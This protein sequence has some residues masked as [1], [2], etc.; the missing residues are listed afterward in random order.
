MPRTLNSGSLRT[1]LGATNRRLVRNLVL[2]ALVTLGLCFLALVYFDKRL[3]DTLSHKLIDQ[4][5]LAISSKLDAY[6]SPFEQGL[7][8]AQEQ[9]ERV[10]FFSGHLAEDFYHVMKPFLRN[11]PHLSAAIAGNIQGSSLFILNDGNGV[12]T[13]EIDMRAK[14]GI[15]QWRRWQDGKVEESWSRRADFDPRTRPWFRN[16]ADKDPGA[17]AYT[18]PYVFYTTQ[19]PGISISRKWRHGETGEEYVLAWDIILQDL[20]ILT[21]SLR[22]TEHGLAMVVTDDATLVGLPAAKRYAQPEARAAAVLES[23]DALDL[24][25]V[26]DAF[27][28]WEQRGRPADIFR[29]RTQGQPWWA[30]FVAYEYLPGRR[31]WTAA[32]VP[33]SDFLAGLSRTRNL[34]IAAIAGGGILLALVI[35]VSSVRSYRRELRN[36]VSRI[37]RKLGQYR[38]EHRIGGGGN[39]TVYRAAHAFLRRPTAVKLMNPEFARS[40]RARVRFEQ[41][42]QAMSGLSHPNTVAVYD[43]GQT[44]DGTLY[45]AMEYLTGLA[46]D[47]MV[48]SWGPVPA[49]RLIYIMRQVCGSLAEA[50]GKGL[51]HRDIKTANIML[52]ER[53]G[54]FDV[55]KVLDFGLV[56]EAGQMDA[57]LTQADALVGTPLFMA[58]ELISEPDRASPQSDI[59]ALGAVGYQLITGRHVF[60][61]AN[62]VEICAAHLQE[63]PVSPSVR[64]GQPVAADLEGVLLACLA[65]K[66]EDR[67]AHALDLDSRLAACGDANGWTGADARDW[68]Q[69]HQNDLPLDY[70]RQTHTPLSN[71]ELL[72]DVSDRLKSSATAQSSP[73]ASR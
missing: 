20:S 11:Y 36:E 10:D 25:P 33:E 59:Y 60:E 27:A 54:V 48:Q 55:V 44:P 50:H 41:E 23:V 2:V 6:F 61:G 14:P 26:Q 3:V 8:I 70:S 16:V 51:I 57:E 65:K 46:L 68:W 56:K 15:S 47:A 67:P 5:T 38:L 24:P 63:E 34:A 72:V 7:I 45:Y 12:L 28:E 62:A 4:T 30:G 71:T 40:D 19:K 22:P 9:L 13:R 31:Y 49:S 1:G 73:P 64:A 29:Y 39:G 53:G 66:P 32:L 35:L 58:P 17:M 69:R 37:E 43:Y 18:E 52:C 42:V 21:T